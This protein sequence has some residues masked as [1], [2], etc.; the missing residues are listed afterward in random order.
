MFEGPSRAPSTWYPSIRLEPPGRSRCAVAR[1]LGA[2]ASAPDAAV[3]ALEQPRHFHDETQGSQGS[4]RPGRPGASH[5]RS[6]SSSC[7][8]RVLRTCASCAPGNRW[9]ERECYT[10]QL[11]NVH[12]HLLITNDTSAARQCDIGGFPIKCHMPVFPLRLAQLLL[13]LEPEAATHHWLTHAAPV[14]RESGRRGQPKFMLS[15]SMQA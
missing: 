2:S 8:R 15:G 6:A 11:K 13:P 7:S 4:R 5:R 9:R 14:A 1:L 10:A 3:P 12:S